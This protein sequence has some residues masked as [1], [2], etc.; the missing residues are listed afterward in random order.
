MLI[1]G[2]TSAEL[3][4]K[5]LRQRVT[6]NGLN[7]EHHTVMCAVIFFDSDRGVVKITDVVDV[8]DD[9]TMASQSPNL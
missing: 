2:M 6:P 1:E 7:I 3:W 8:P 4:G 9:E 5:L